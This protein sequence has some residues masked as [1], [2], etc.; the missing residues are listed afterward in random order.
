VNDFQTIGF[1]VEGT[2]AR[3]TLV[4]PARQAINR[5]YQIMGM[6]QALAEALELD[7]EIESTQSEQRQES[8]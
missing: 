1:S 4:R 6:P 3:I 7:V 8:A 2:I 5:C